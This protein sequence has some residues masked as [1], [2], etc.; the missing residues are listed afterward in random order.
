MINFLMLFFL[1]FQLVPTQQS[2]LEWV[3]G[4][5][6]GPCYF[7]ATDTL[8]DLCFL[9]SGGGVYILDIN[10]PSNPAIISERIKTEG[11]YRNI[12]Y[13]YDQQMLFIQKMTFPNDSTFEYRT[14]TWDVSSIYNP[15]FVSEYNFGNYHR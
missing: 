1:S 14:E 10:D 8:R 13:N 4:W 7:C 2:D 3:G 5:P 9:Q 12:T 15:A 11:R 6:F